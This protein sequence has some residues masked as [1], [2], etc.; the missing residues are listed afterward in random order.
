MLSRS[1]A[2]INPFKTTDVHNPN[3]HL[4]R[5]SVRF[6][7]SA[8]VSP[9]TPSKAMVRDQDMGWDLRYYDSYRPA[10]EG[11]TSSEDRSSTIATESKA[12]RHRSNKIW[13]R[14]EYSSNTTPRADASLA[15]KFSRGQSDDHSAAAA[16]VPNEKS[17]STG[18]DPKQLI[19]MPT[20]ERK[21]TSMPDTSPSRRSSRT[22]DPDRRNASEAQSRGFYGSSPPPSNVLRLSGYELKRPLDDEAID[23]SI[24][25]HRGTEEEEEEEPIRTSDNYRPPPRYWCKNYMCME[26][27]AYSD[28]DKPMICWGCRSIR[29]VHFGVVLSHY[30][31]S[32]QLVRHVLRNSREFGFLVL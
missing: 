7:L 26:D 14:A 11:E 15:L 13:H 1:D 3:H 17:P 28:C 5:S 4:S 2:T 23:R 18:H 24:K 21:D 29:S 12:V 22:V 30:W 8:S 20:K 32:M 10:A 9:L 6:P 19:Q 27:H 31:T 25:R 16:S